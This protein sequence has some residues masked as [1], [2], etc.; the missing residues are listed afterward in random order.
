V[1]PR[2]LH[3]LGSFH[4]GGSERQAISLAQALKHEG[5]FD[6]SLAVLNDEGSLRD[7][8][9]EI[10]GDVP[11]FPINSFYRPSFLK[12]VRAFAAHLREQKI[13]VIHTTDFYTNV[14]GMAASASAGTYA[15]I[16]SKRE[17]DGMR[18]KNQD[19]VER[20]AFGAAS[21]I[22][23]NSQ[24][25]LDHLVARGV[26]DSRIELIYNGVDVA[27]FDNAAERTNAVL[28]PYDIPGGTRLITLVANL[29]HG[30]KN[31]PMFLRVADRITQ[32]HDDVRF[33]IAGEGE[34]KADLEAMAAQLGVEEYVYFTGRCEDIPALLAASCACVLTS[35][36][37]GFSN[38]ILE[39]MAAGKP[40]VATNVG[41]AAEAIVEGETG[42]IVT[43]NDDEQ[44]AARLLEL[45]ND[46]DLAARFGTAAR[47]RVADNFST[48]EQL[49]KTIDLYDRL[50]A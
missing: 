12:Q 17:T 19:R 45:L 33:V 27:R 48:E 35:M 11:A 29:R 42:Y 15:R 14:F 3:L 39:Y 26:K 44:M 21:K 28:E 13:D 25:V 36:A 10:A 49:L 18:T 50:L 46:A 32:R 31:I 34:I 2:V 6:V 47:Q 1:K 20:F 4:N 16:A 22:I 23:V 9:R 24:A 37:E 7:E 30:V 40:V 5:S 38:S 41:G 43:S 8:A